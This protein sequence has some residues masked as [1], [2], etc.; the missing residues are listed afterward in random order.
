MFKQEEQLTFGPRGHFLNHL[1]CFSPDDEWVVY[2]TRNDDT[3]IQQT[4]SIEMVNTA[5]KEIRVLYQVSQPNAHGPGVGAATFSPVADQVIFIHGIR[6]SNADRP[7]AF[8]RRTG[9]SI[10]LA[11][12][13]EPIF[14]DARNIYPPF[15]PGALRGGTHAHSWSGDGKWIV[16]TYNDEIIAQLAK[17][18]PDRKDLRTVGVMFPKPVPVGAEATGENNSGE[19]FTVLVA[20]VTENPM[21]GSDQIDRAFDETWVGK[22]G[23]QKTD[24]TWQK[25]AIAFQGNVR[26]LAGKLQT[27]VFMVDLPD[28]DTL[29]VARD[30]DWPLAGT[31]SQLPGIPKGVVQR[32]I[33]FTPDGLSGPRFWLR[34]TP[35][36]KWIAFLAKDQQGIINIFAISPNGGPIK[37]LTFNREPISGQFNFSSDGKIIA[38]VAGGKIHLTETESGM[39]QQIEQNHLP[40][41]EPTG[42]VVWANRRNDLIYN[43]YIHEG[44]DKYLQVFI[45]KGKDK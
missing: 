18:N 31:E 28:E 36:G 27:E 10:Q 33:S 25:R 2:D 8:T 26:T 37:Q 7:Y 17:T 21:P 34:S 13:G 23:Y 4:S 15:T 22:T 1:Q 39:T 6:N 45:L 11:Q 14:M 42:A 32:R 29:T 19:M 41:E 20:E 40:G 43:R 44:N 12:P 24:G 30:P 3:Q 38:Y 16:F 35:D 5:T 9:V